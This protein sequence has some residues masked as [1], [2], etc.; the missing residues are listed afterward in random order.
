MLVNLEGAKVVNHHG[1]HSLVLNLEKQFEDKDVQSLNV[2]DLFAK[3]QNPSFLAYDEED[4]Q[5]L[6]NAGYAKDKHSDLWSKIT[7]DKTPSKFPSPGGIFLISMDKSFDTAGD[8]MPSGRAKFIHAVGATGK[9][10]FVHKGGKY[11]GI[12]QGAD[13]GLI[14]LSSAA[15]PSDSQPLAPGM[16]L[17]FLRDGVDSANLVSMYGV[18][19]TPDDWN[20]FSKDFS[21]HIGPAKGVALNLLATKF[22]SATNFIQEVGLSDFARYDEAGTEY[23]NPSFPFS[24]R[25]APHSAVKSLFPKS[26]PDDYMAYVDQLASVPANS[27]LYKVYAMDK[28]KELGGKETLI[29]DLVLDGSLVSSKWGDE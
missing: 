19:G 24:L 25:F 4:L 9:V 13:Y 5:N 8:V 10:K 20:F 21:N 28:P 3:Q 18:N 14:R 7:A 15:E 17:K 6:S 11:T 22:S 1:H 12:F 16:G 29:G 23:R 26:K 27:A 2:Q